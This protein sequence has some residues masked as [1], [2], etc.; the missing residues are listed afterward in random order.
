MSIF[1]PIYEICRSRYSKQLESEPW[2]I[3]VIVPSV[4]SAWMFSSVL[5]TPISL[6]K[7]RLQTASAMSKY[8]QGSIPST[9]FLQVIK[10]IYAS[11]G[12]G[13]FY[14]GYR[15]VLV[16][17]VVYCLYFSLYEPL[18]LY[19]VNSLNLPLLAVVPVLSPLTMIAVS[20]VTYPNDL[21]I[22]NLQFQ[23]KSN[24]GN[25]VHY[26]GWM[27]AFKSIYKAG[28]VSGLYAGL[29]TYLLRFCLGTIVTQTSYETILKF[30][31]KER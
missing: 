29:S 21:I 8:S 24:N 18:K 3:S 16:L 1:F 7:V 26:K 12:L 10:N 15:G 20:S 11:E 14:A 27:D 31:K 6:V 25:I 2:H 30:M 4:L 28:G 22:S 13:G 23:G 9:S 17:S 19:C 5:V